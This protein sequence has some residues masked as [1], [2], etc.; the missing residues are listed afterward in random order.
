MNLM[1]TV[2]FDSMHELYLHTYLLEHGS[3]YGQRNQL[4]VN[5][6]ILVR[7]FILHPKFLI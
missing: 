1:K 4:I 2:A 7:I 5:Q 3:D 6:A